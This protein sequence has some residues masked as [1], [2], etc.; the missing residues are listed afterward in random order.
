MM[1]IALLFFAQADSLPI[2]PK[3]GQ[4]SPMRLGD[5]LTIVGVGLALAALLFLIVFLTRKKREG[6]SH[7]PSSRVLVSSSRRPHDGSGRVRV[8]K[9]RRRHPDNLPRNPTLGQTGGLP[10]V[11]SEDS[12][13]PAD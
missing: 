8:K 7:V 9:K 6:N 12:P 5:T 13:G 1:L 11:R 3:T 2:G 10:P 4:R